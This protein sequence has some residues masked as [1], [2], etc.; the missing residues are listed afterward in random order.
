MF[1]A[2]FVFVHLVCSW[3]CLSQCIVAFSYDCL[4]RLVLLLSHYICLIVQ[5]YLPSRWVWQVSGLFSAARWICTPASQGDRYHGNVMYAYRL[6][7][8]V[9]KKHFLNCRFT[10]PPFEMCCFN[11]QWKAACHQTRFC[12][13]AIQKVPFF[14]TPCIVPMI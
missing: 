3:T 13:T 9:P 12:K 4:P 5:Y 1:I 7:Q 10:G 11:W 6:L 8:G 14:G 2:V